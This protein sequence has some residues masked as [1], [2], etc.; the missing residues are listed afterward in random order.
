MRLSECLS[1]WLSQR[2]TDGPAMWL[3][4]EFNL[5]FLCYSQMPNDFLSS[6]FPLNPSYTHL[7]IWICIIVSL[8]QNVYLYHIMMAFGLVKVLFS[9]LIIKQ[10]LAI[11]LDFHF[12]VFVVSTLG[13]W[14]PFF[15]VEGFVKTKTFLPL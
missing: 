2:P 11:F 15:R 6:F 3:S 9:I 13:S 4:V 5:A 14:K 1:D 8:Q 10:F 12:I 7:P